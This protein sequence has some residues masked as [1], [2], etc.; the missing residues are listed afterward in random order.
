MLVEEIKIKNFRGIR[1]GT[2]SAFAPLS[3]LVGPNNSGKSTVLEAL[4]VHAGCGRVLR[5]V[6][7]LKR[8]AWL[9]LPALRYLFFDESREAAFEAASGNAVDLRLAGKSNLS[10]PAVL[11]KDLLPLLADEGLGRPVEELRLRSHPLASNVRATHVAINSQGKT[12]DVVLDG[13]SEPAPNTILLDVRAITEQGTLEEAYSASGKARFETELVELVAPLRPGL[14]DL[15][16][17]KDGDL[18]NLHILDRQGSSPVYFAGDGFKRLVHVACHLAGATGGLAMIE[19]PECFQH[20][21]SLEMLAKL[22][23]GAVE[24]GTQIVL[25]THS[26]ELIEA[27]M[28]EGEPHLF[29]E[30]LAVLRTSL[31][32]GK[33]TVVKGPGDEAYERLTEIGEDLRV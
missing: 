33:L 23:W 13:P 25:S 28:R 5:V 9:G 10:W 18:Y 29:G 20:P 15:R 26:L 6:E 11:S 8:R 3:I 16:I 17:L 2:V 32:A 27:L 1:E 31:E 14:E 4:W 30:R 24:R 19:E 21:K 22:L 12:S 7:V